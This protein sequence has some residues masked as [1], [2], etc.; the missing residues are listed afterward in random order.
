LPFRVYT[1]IR[2]SDA[3]TVIPL[4]ILLLRVVS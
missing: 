2:V 4:G 1:T 3:F